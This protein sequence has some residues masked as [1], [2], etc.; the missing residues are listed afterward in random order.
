MSNSSATA[1]RTIPAFNTSV[2]EMNITHTNT[3]ITRN[4]T[5][6]LPQCDLHVLTHEQFINNTE[7]HGQKWAEIPAMDIFL[8]K[9]LTHQNGTFIE[10]GAFDG[11]RFSNTLIFEKHFGWRGLLIEPSPANIPK[12]RRSRPCSIAVHAALVSFANDSQLINVD[13]KASPTT[14]TGSQAKTSMTTKVRGRAI[15]NILDEAGIT[16]VDFWSLDVE[17]NE[18]EALQGMNFTKHRPKIILVEIWNRNPKIF[19]HMAQNGY[20]LLKDGVDDQGSVSFW[21]HKTR[22]RDFLFLDGRSTQ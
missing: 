10:S 3:S 8:K 12:I 16:I 18:L 2:P 11:M 17:G 9:Y 19:N 20:E 1:R 14:V 15:S 5:N 21:K 22:H 4:N 6:L 7:S 13:T